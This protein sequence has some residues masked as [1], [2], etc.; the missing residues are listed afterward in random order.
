ME[1]IIS[2][3]INSSP[4]LSIAIPTWNRSAILKLCLDKLLPQ[5]NDHKSLIQFVICDNFSD[6]STQDTINDS[7]GRFSNLN[8][9]SFRQSSNTGYFGNF[10]KCRE[11]SNGKYF[12]LL[13]DND[14]IEDGLIS[15]LIHELNN[16]APEFIFLK[17]WGLYNEGKSS[18]IEFSKSSMDSPSFFKQLG[19]RSTL[20]SSIIFP[21]NKSF[22][23]KIYLALEKNTF[24]GFFLFLSSI[25]VNSDCLIVSGVSLNIYPT[26][27]SFNV[28]KSFG[29]DLIKGLE[30]LKVNMNFSPNIIDYIVNLCII[31]ITSRHYIVYRVFG[32]VHNVNPG[33]KN[34]LENF[35]QLKFSDY[36]AFDSHLKPLFQMNFLQIF[37]LFIKRKVSPYLRKKFK[38]V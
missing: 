3:N 33:S 18:L 37:I 20:I 1:Q 28:F 12:W 30:Y 23:S 2:K 5:I 8:F 11:L 14:F 10:K 6:D 16:S 19:D 34:D 4:L 38:L 36:K 29:E 21:N 22:D 24:L 31:N 7:L 9:I 26:R 25:N 32:K 35:L 27:V 17:D 13:S 15:F